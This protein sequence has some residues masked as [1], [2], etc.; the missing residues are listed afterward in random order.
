MY[1]FET[2]VRSLSV[3]GIHLHVVAQRDEFVLDAGNERGVVAAGKIGAPDAAVK[4]HVAGDEK[5]VFAAEERNAAG[6]VAGRVDD[7]QPGMAKFD[8]FT[9]LHEAA[10]LG[11]KLRFGQAV[12]AAHLGYCLEDG[13]IVAV[14]FERQAVSIGYKGIAENVI[15]VAMGIEQAHGAQLSAG[16]F[17]GQFIAFADIVAAGVND[18]ALAGVIVDQISV[19]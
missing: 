18:D 11:R 10:R 19:F 17:A 9:F 1:P 5:A 15:E 7:F 2:D 6:R 8:H 13:Q 14:N 12:H 4:Q 3:P 16:Y